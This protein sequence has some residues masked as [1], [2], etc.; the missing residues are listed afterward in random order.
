MYCLL[1]RVGHHS[2]SKVVQ[3][4]SVAVHFVVRSCG[5]PFIVKGC[6]VQICCRALCC[7][8][9]WDTIHRQRLCS[10][11]LL[12]CTLLYV[13]VGHHSSSKVVQCRSVAVHFVVRTGLTYAQSELSKLVSQI[14][15]C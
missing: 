14:V 6:A 1:L 13:R 15:K 5:T 11:D 8:F 4:R 12:P 10:A 2:S 9:V 3:C 7:T